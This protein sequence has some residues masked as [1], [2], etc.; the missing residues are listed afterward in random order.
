MLAA[1]AGNETQQKYME[2]FKNKV[3]CD[4]II[5]VEKRFLAQWM[6]DGSVK[7]GEA[8]CVGF[9][10]DLQRTAGTNAD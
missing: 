8:R 7:P 5:K 6:P 10:P 9:V 1:A 4:C 3:S 2:R